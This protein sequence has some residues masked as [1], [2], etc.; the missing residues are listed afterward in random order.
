MQSADELASAAV[1]D[2]LFGDGITSHADMGAFVAADSALDSA[3]SADVAA[4]AESHYLASYLRLP[5]SL[6]ASAAAE[7]YTSYFGSADGGD[8]TVRSGDVSGD[9]LDSR[10]DHLGMLDSYSGSPTTS[11]TF[12]E[13]VPV[14][15]LDPDHAREQVLLQQPGFGVDGADTPDIDMLLAEPTGACSQASVGRSVP[16]WC[17]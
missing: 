12:E 16:C 8:S 13:D 4:A 15:S 9:E 3:V 5:D 11:A 14:S 10:M 1:V 17:I 2:R 7:T 6:D